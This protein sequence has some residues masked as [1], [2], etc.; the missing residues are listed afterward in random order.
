MPLLVGVLF[1][2]PLS[3]ITSD[4]SRRRK[5]WLEASGRSAAKTVDIR[6]CAFVI[7]AH[8]KHVVA[9]AIRA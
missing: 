2:M 5:L 3:N 1:A 9:V 6:V 7:H 8:I 4:S